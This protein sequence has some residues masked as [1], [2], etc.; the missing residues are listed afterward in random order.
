M[1]A[2]GSVVLYLLALDGV[3]CALLAWTDTTPS[4]LAGWAAALAVALAVGERAGEAFAVI[5]AKRRDRVAVFLGTLQLSVLVLALVL[6]A[7]KPTPGLLGFLA[8]V[9]AGYQLLV[10]A[11][12]RLAPQ[13]RGVVGQSLALVALACLRGGPIGAWAAASALGLVGLYV[14]LDH[15]AR[16]LAFHRLDDR[17]HGARALGLSALVVLPVAVAV[18]LA[19]YTAAPEPRPDPPPERVDDSY[20]PLE[21]KPKRELDARAL[22]SIV[23]AGLAGAVAVYFVG[24]WIVRSKRGVKGSME[25]P[26]PLRGALERIR[27]DERPRRAVPAYPGRRGKVVRA[28][29]R[30]LRATERLGFPRRPDETPAQF[31]R[32]LG[33]PRAPLGEATEVFVR[34]RYGPGDVA[35]G[36]VQAAERGVAGVLA[37]LERHPPPR[38]VVVRDDV[39]APAA[40]EDRPAARGAASP[41]R[42]PSSSQPA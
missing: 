2:L 35:D 21:E 39:G 40:E 30:L 10:L 25:A 42:P 20:R 38:R 37:H 22:R 41:A 36:D 16:L 23:V 31:A 15:H 18:G 13:A 26:E 14:G 7:G 27:P 32:A 12:A 34:A 5:E 28:Y 6:A 9:L 11:L 4:G 24:R 29:L 1:S 19:I 17:G 8:G 33:E 3:A